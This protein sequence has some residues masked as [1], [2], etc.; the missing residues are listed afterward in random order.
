MDDLG[1]ELIKAFGFDPRVP[2]EE[3]AALHAAAEARKAEEKAKAP[4]RKPER[5]S[6]PFMHFMDCEF[7]AGLKAVDSAQELAV[8]LHILRERRWRQRIGQ[9]EVFALTNGT[10]RTWAGISKTTKN[11]AL[12][13]LAAAG[14]IT[15]EA[16]GQRSPQVS[17]CLPG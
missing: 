15:I 17:V 12:Q 7:L 3:V 2:A 10:L 5:E 14:L 6:Q 1:E 9:P 13:K 11:R 8:W 16:R 4:R